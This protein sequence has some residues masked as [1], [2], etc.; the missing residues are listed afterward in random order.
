[1]IRRPPRSTRT[2]TLFPYTT[3]FRSGPLPITYVHGM[4][5][6]LAQ[7]PG[8][9]GQGRVQTSR[10]GGDRPFLQMNYSLILSAGSRP[11]PE[12]YSFPVNISANLPG[13]TTGTAW[14]G[15]VPIGVGARSPGQPFTDPAKPDRTNLPP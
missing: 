2:D 1:M 10:L 7:A 15:C 8:A 5:L 14:E 11:G 12:S 4:D 6:S 13:A 3:L 9:D